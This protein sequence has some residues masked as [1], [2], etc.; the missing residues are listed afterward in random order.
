MTLVDWLSP[1]L[2]AEQLRDADRR[3]IEVDGIPGV[4]LMERAATALAQAI[5]E[6]AP[7]GRVAVLVG[8]GNN[9]GDGLAAARILRQAGREVDV[10]A[11]CESSDWTGD[12]QQ[13]AQTLVGAPPEPFGHDQ[14]EEVACVVDCILGT[15]AAGPLRGSVAD[16]VDAICAA[17]DRGALVVACD[18]PTGVDPDTGEVGAKVVRADVTVSF[19]ALKP[20]LAINPGKSCAGEVQLADIGIAHVDPGSQIGLIEDAVVARLPR[21]AARGDK[22][23]AGSVLVTGGSPGLTGAP[24]LAGLGAARGGAG[25]VT[26]GLPQSLLSASDLIPELM[27]LGLADC[28]GHHC[29]EGSSELLRRVRG[30]NACVVGPGLGRAQGAAA[31]VLACI[32]AVERPLVIDADGLRALEGQLDLIAARDAVTVLTPHAGEM[33]SLIGLDRAEVEKHRL[34]SVREAAAASGAVVLLKGDDTLICDPTGL[35]AISRG[36]APGLATAGTGDVLSGLIAAN[37]ARGVEPFEASCAAV[38]VHAEAGRIAAELGAEGVMATD[39]AAALQP[40]RARLAAAV[41][42]R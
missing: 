38:A 36:N 33:A 25:Y 13:M 31:L 1:L 16:A 26:V 39:V 7:Q 37:L 8:K 6:V 21:R 32:Q 9:G 23:T 24:M 41:P 30:A 4:D 3:A 40:A 12:A 29:V 11:T 20:G 28:E 19:H 34:R 27:G 42:G 15:G 17:R 10:L 5:C 14:L 22:F 18:L 35:T 2:S